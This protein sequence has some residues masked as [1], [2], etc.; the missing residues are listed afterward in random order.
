MFVGFSSNPRQHLFI[1]SHDGYDTDTLPL[2]ARSYEPKITRFFA[3]KIKI[4]MFTYS[5]MIVVITISA[6]L[7]TTLTL[8]AIL[9]VT[10]A[11]FDLW[12]ACNDSRVVPDNSDI[13]RNFSWFT[14]ILYFSAI[15]T[16]V[17]YVLYR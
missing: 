13:R 16:T 2:V 14:S 11:N 8:I 17:C 10:L 4:C 7:V 12:S 5:Y 1:V 15:P 6:I 3:S 9:Y